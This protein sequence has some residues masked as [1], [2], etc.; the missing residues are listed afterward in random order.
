MRKW[1]GQYQRKGKGTDFFYLLP[2]K[3]RDGCPK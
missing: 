2:W 3:K 1:K